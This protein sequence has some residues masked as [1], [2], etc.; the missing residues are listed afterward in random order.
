MVKLC[1]LGDSCKYVYDYVNPF[2]QKKTKQRVWVEKVRVYEHENN[3]A[4]YV[5]LQ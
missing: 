1:L 3:W 4:E 5:G 2:I